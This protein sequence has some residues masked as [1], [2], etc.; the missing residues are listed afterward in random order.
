MNKNKVQITAISITVLIVGLS[1]FVPVL[2]FSA[3][4]RSL[5]KKSHPRTVIQTNL[6]SEYDD[7]YL[8][9][10]IH[11]FYNTSSEIDAANVEESNDSEYFVIGSSGF[12][13]LLTK[14]FDEL[15]NLG[16]SSLPFLS[17]NYQGK[18]ATLDYYRKVN[19]AD[20]GN[21]QYSFILED[22]CNFSYDY[23]TQAD[24]MFRI[25]LFYDYQII[26]YDPFQ[27]VDREAVLS[28]YIDYLQLDCID[29]W[30][31]NGTYMYSEKTQLRV[32]CSINTDY[33]YYLELMIT[34]LEVNN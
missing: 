24:K 28:K 23:C 34:P 31:Y 19:D 20:F 7:I 3:K 11:E 22:E 6:D 32:S 33:Q 1:L 4:D 18:N 10:F 5:L 29:D 13:S 30:V 25:W 15:N 27:N 16:L 8:V 2:N 26:T 17:K 12:T 21:E 9:K 14:Q